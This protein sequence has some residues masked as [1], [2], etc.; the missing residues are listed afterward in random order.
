MQ[1]EAQEEREPLLNF[2]NSKQEKSIFPKL[3]LALITIVGI[4]FLVAYVFYIPYR[5]ELAIREDNGTFEL[6]SMIFSTF[7][8]SFHVYLNASLGLS[9][10]PPVTGK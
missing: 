4:A 5:I 10:I 8:E 3:L 7:K 2:K 1:T 9:E 6:N